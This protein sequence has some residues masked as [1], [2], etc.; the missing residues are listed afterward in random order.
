MGLSELE[1]TDEYS[2]YFMTS[3]ISLFNN[4]VNGEKLSKI[5][6]IRALRK[7]SE[8]RIGYFSKGF[9]DSLIEESDLLMD[10]D[11]E[12]QLE[13]NCDTEIP[14]CLTLVEKIYI[15][16]ILK[17][18]Y[19]R[20]LLD[21]N[22]IAELL[23][24][25][26]DVP[27]ISFDR[28]FQFAGINRKNIISD[29]EIENIRMILKAI[30]EKK[31]LRYSNRAGNGKLYENM[32]CYPVRLEYSLIQDEF[33]VSV[34][35]ASEE[36][37]V[38]LNVKTLFD[39]SIEA[40]F[41]DGDLSP[42]EMMRKHIN[43]EPLIVEVKNEKNAIERFNFAFSMY[44]KWTELIDEDNVCICIRYYD[45]DR[46]EI[47]NNLLS[48]GTTVKVISPPEMI[49]CIVKRIKDNM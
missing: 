20:I 15:K 7:A 35:S 13:P 24:S 38:K 1:L 37:P 32:L 28:V 10:T 36:L 21:D 47:I 3:F 29:S 2:N 8:D 34:W 23:K 31:I 26:G 43:A 45:F 49:D 19:S 33:S 18:R 9:M 46:Y 27:D 41:R 11:D 16:S 17:S 39:V 4:T 40:E 25:L 30:N 6:F 48:F 44:D 12:E 5:G 22:V 14:T 42:Q